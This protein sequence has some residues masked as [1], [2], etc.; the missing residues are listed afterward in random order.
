MKKLFLQI[1][2]LL[3]IATAL[4]QNKYVY[5]M[6][7]NS[8]NIGYYYVEYSNNAS[9]KSNTL[10][11]QFYDE[12]KPCANLHVDFVIKR[13]TISAVT[14]DKGCVCLDFKT[15]AP[16]VLLTVIVQPRFRTIEYTRKCV[17]FWE[18][19]EQNRPVKLNVFV[20][21]QYDPVVHIKSEKSLSIQ[22]MEDIRNAILSGNI[23]SI[24]NKGVEVSEEI[25]L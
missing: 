24:N 11:A 7:M 3:P 18:W 25:H 23:K 9:S 4:S 19:N 1:L 10:L 2:L 6:S 16:D 15:L 17:Y 12:S 22:D 5:E 21:K 14:D 8:Y 20:E 13:D